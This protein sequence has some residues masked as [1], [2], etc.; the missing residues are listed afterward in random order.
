MKRSECL[1]LLVP[2]VTA[3]MLTTTSLSTNTAL[4]SGMSKA[5]ANF[6]GL[7]MG[8][9][10]PFAMG[11]CLAFPQRQVLA[12][13]SDGS[14]MVDPGSLITAADNKLTNLAILVFDNGAYARM[15]PTATT[16]GTD[17]EKMA[18]GAGIS[19]TRT[20][21]TLDEF[22]DAMSTVLKSPGPS[23]VLA[24][25]EAETVRVHGEP[26]RVYG[27]NMREIFVDN[28]RAFPDYWLKR[29]TPPQ[30]G[31]SPSTPQHS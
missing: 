8:L 11:L 31:G 23:F 29:Y 5:G 25:I 1:P 27:R 14:L 28:T 15:G 12:I 17:L 10:V 7:N 26:R 22:T 18:Q 16:R 4:W 6:F 19:L 20:I 3:E 13:D 2:L 9:C 30:P 21:Q 24:K